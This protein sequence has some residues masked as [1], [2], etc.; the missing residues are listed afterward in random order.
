ML[1]NGSYI[2]DKAREGHFGVGAFNVNDFCATEAI[3][4]AAEE[5]NTPVI[6][7]IGDWTD[8]NAAESKHKSD[9]DAKNFMH[10]VVYRADIA[11]VPVC[12]HLDHCRTYEGCIRSIKLGATSV[13]LDASMC[14]FEE[15]IALTNKVIE[16]AHGCGVSVEA[17]IGHVAGHVG[18]TTGDLYT[19]VDEAKRFYAATGV[20]SL[21]VAIGTIHGIYEHEPVLQYD[22]I[23]ELRDAIPAPLVM[24]GASGLVPEQYA[25]CVKRGI[26]KINFAT[27]MQLAGAD[28]I[29]AMDAAGKAKGERVRAQSYIAAATAGMHDIVKEHIGYF[30]TQPIK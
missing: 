13:M 25:E 19:T 16:A 23:S 11:K 8:P 9:W 18:D 21:A 26:T 17:E 30:K 5:T 3:I 22:R 10:Y 14:S 1:V 20:D 7:Q 6:V 12:I 29:E 24:H 4:T 28:A 2:L 27:Y 15:N